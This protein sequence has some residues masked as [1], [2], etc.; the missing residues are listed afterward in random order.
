MALFTNSKNIFT[1]FQNVVYLRFNKIITKSFY[2][3]NITI[4]Y[5]KS[6][7]TMIY[8]KL[9]EDK[10]YAVAFSAKK[11]NAHIKKIKLLE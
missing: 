8:F 3:Q 6:T 7:K 4:I 5:T 9:N 11:V 1:K 10:T 2:N